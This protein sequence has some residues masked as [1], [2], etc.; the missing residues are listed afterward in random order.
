VGFLTDLF[1]KRPRLAYERPAGWSEETVQGGTLLLAPELEQDWQANIF[2]E[3]LKDELSRDLETAMQDHLASVKQAKKITKVLVTKVVTLSH[4]VTGAVIQYLHES[5]G[6]VLRDREVMV[7][8][9][10]D[11]VGFVLTSTVETLAPKYD[12]IFDRFLSTLRLS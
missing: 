4:G 3:T 5:D 6:M 1:K 2:I 11:A 9:G 8:L 12:P 10:G 7:P